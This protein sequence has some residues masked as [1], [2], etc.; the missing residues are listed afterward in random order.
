MGEREKTGR[1]QRFLRMVVNPLQDGCGTDF[2]G[3]RDAAFCLN[4]K[5]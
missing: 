2:M 3:G 1:Q 4:Q 5:R